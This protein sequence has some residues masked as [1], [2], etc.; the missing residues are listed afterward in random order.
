MGHGY[1]I[2]IT[3]WRADEG[4]IFFSVLFNEMCLIGGSREGTGGP[5]HP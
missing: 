1:I 4:V 2:N 3:V 5:D